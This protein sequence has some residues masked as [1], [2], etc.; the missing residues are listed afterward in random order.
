MARCC[1]S[2]TRPKRLRVD[3]SVMSYTARA[4]A[5]A[6]P[7]ASH[8]DKFET[9]RFLALRLAE[10]VARSRI[11]IPGCHCAQFGLLANCYAVSD[12]KWLSAAPAMPASAIIVSTAGNTPSTNAP[13]PPAAP[14]LPPRK[15][16]ALHNPEPCPAFAGA[17]ADDPSPAAK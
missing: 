11:T 6:A 7:L 15:V 12:K 16:H 14:E 2:G 4:V 9:L 5:G 8:V 1:S 10:S 3:T 17:S 13:A